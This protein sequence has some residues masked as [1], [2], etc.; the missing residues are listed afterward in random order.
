MT[1]MPQ[2]YMYCSIWGSQWGR[3]SP[4]EGNL[5]LSP[6]LIL[7]SPK[8]KAHGSA[9]GPHF[10]FWWAT[11]SSSN[12]LHA[13]EAPGIFLASKEAICSYRQVLLRHKA[14][15]DNHFK[16]LTLSFYIYCRSC[17]AFTTIRLQD[18]LITP[19]KVSVFVNTHFS[20]HSGLEI[21]HLF[22]VSLGLL[23]LDFLR[24]QDSTLCALLGLLFPYRL[25]S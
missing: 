20:V 10:L 16:A 24:K 13:L 6:S 11:D 21:T 8:T 18:I 3:V 4:Q 14:H 1:L 17:L 23:V 2:L 12:V 5:L 25:C 22:L 7:P 19:H 9:T 15:K